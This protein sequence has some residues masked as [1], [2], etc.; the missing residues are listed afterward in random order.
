M[1]TAHSLIRP[2][3][4]IGINWRK[5][6]RNTYGG[7]AHAWV[8]LPADTDLVAEVTIYAD[9]RGCAFRIDVHDVTDLRDPDPPLV[10]N[11]YEDGIA[12]KHVA[13]ALAIARLFSWWKDQS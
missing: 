13:Q 8:H 4:Q 1:T 6:T 5:L 3:D 10:M 9:A 2:D 11:H 12:S 7:V